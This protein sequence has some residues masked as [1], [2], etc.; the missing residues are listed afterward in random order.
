MIIADAVMPAMVP[1]EGLGGV[2]VSSVGVSVNSMG[3]EDVVVICVASVVE[4]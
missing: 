2:D 3:V 4:G 1:S